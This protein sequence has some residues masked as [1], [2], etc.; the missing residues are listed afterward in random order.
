M[1]STYVLYLISCFHV[2]IKAEGE[3]LKVRRE[4][5]IKIATTYTSSK[6][7]ILI[8]Y[9]MVKDLNCICIDVYGQFSN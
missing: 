8:P 6:Q 7:V 3:Q 5:Q 9:A 2:Q 4:N 1:Y